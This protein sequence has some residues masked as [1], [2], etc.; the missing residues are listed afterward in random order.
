[1]N[2]WQI[3]SNQ[4]RQKKHGDVPAVDEGAAGEAKDQ[5]AGERAARARLHCAGTFPSSVTP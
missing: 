5:K 3:D 1:M 2:E 4:P